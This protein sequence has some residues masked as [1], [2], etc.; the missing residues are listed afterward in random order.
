VRQLTQ[1]A[2][3]AF[4]AA[5]VLASAADAASCKD[6]KTHKFVTCPPPAAAAP[7]SAG[8]PHC[9]VGKPCGKS[10]IAKNKVCTIK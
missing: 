1:I 9:K 6:P 3:I 10:C 7:S 8:L 5:F 2:A 4:A